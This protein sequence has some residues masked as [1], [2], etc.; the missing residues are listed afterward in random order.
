MTQTAEMADVVFPAAAGW[1]ES[2]G[3]VTNSERRVQRV[4]RGPAAAHRGSRRYRDYLVSFR[5][6]WGTIWG[7]RRRKKFGMKCAA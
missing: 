6:A 5:A 4:R 2:D 1:C 7:I 3:T